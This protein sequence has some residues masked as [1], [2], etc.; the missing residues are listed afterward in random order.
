MIWLSTFTPESETVSLSDVPYEE[1]NDYV[2]ADIRGTADEEVSE[3]LRRPENVQ[4]WY[5][6]LLTNRNNVDSQLANGKAER[7]KMFAECVSKGSAGKQ[8]WL[9]YLAAHDKWRAGAIR[10]KN[11]TEVKLAEAKMLARTQESV[12]IRERNEAIERANTL[13]AA[14]LHHRDTVDELED[15]ADR[16]LWEAVNF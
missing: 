6:C 16:I 14:I 1:F 9:D 7:S 11:G 10:F 5:T 12:V 8:E 13:R 2:N 4:R 15:E 3:E